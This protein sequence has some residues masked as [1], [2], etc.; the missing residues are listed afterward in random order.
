[1]AMS[2]TV[3]AA[4]AARTFPSI[5]RRV[6]EGQSFTITEHGVPIAQITPFDEESRAR[7]IARDALIRDL[8]DRPIIKAIPWTRDELYEDS[9]SRERAKE[10]L[11]EHLEQV[12]V[13]DIGPWAREE[14]YEDEP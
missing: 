14:L 2:E 6:R 1:M 13:K 4:E 10:R 12:Q 8:R 9:N 5:L 11:L 3:T 7:E